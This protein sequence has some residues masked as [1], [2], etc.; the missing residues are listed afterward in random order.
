MI[1]FN[2]PQSTAGRC[3]NCGEFA[4]HIAADCKLEAQPKKC[5]HCK[6]ADHL[7]ADC[8]TRTVSKS[9]HQQFFVLSE[10]INFSSRCLSF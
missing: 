1:F 5:H 7:I 9:F 8:P 4:D 6:S 2:Q 10:Q 3:Y